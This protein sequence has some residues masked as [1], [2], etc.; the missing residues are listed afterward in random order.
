MASAPGPAAP[1]P[2]APE[3]AAAPLSVSLGAAGADPSDA[4]NGQ[5]VTVFQ[6]L[7]PTA[8]AA[9]LVDFEIY[10]S[11]GRK[12]WQTW[13]ENLPFQG[14]AMTTDFATYTI[15]GDLPPGRY[16]FKTGVFST[17][18]GTLYAWNDNAGAFTVQD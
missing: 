6:D 18:W 15:P 12:V 9:L 14:G 1:S 17:G 2:G 3:A 5:D 7:M 4:S 8:D 13:H 10:D 11:Q 16:T